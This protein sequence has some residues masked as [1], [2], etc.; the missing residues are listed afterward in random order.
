MGLSVSVSRSVVIIIVIVIINI[1]IS[2][3]DDGFLVEGWQ[4]FCSVDFVECL[5]V[6]S[7]YVAI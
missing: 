3:N 5:N 7:V 1:V 4:T 6:D 2:C